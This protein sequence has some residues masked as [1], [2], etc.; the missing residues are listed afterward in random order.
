[1]EAL[2]NLLNVFFSITLLIISALMCLLLVIFV[3]WL[4]GELKKS[5]TKELKERRNDKN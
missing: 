5:I 2:N 3:I 4:F 1:M